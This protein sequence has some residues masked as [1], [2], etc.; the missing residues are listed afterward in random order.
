MTHSLLQIYLL[1]SIHLRSISSILEWHLLIAFLPDPT[2]KMVLGVLTNEQFD[3]T[4]IKLAEIISRIQKG[5]QE[6]TQPKKVLLMVFF[7]KFKKLY[8]SVKSEFAIRFLREKMFLNKIIVEKVPDT[9]TKR[10]ISTR[11][12][13]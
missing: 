3:D 9:C 8:C 6:K 4:L 12:T 2:G 10:N 7:T 1:D 13:N 5:K 11:R